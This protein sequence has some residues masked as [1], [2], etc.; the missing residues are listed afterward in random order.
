[1]RK[2]FYGWVIVGV[3]FLIGVTEAGVF[4]NILSIFM[5]P[6]AQEFGWSRASV[7]GAIAI[8]SIC[9]GL[10]SLL[11]GPILDRYGSRMVA[12]WGIVFLSIGLSALM[13]IRHLWQLYLFFGVG[14]MIAVGMLSLVISVSVSNWFIL[15]RGR[16]LGITW[17]GE[18][19]GS[20]L[21]PVM[22]QLLILAYGWRLTWGVLGVVVF[23]L[24]GIPALLFLRRRPEDMGLLPDNAGPASEKKGVDDLLEAKNPGGGSAELAEPIWTRAQATRTKT[25]WTLTLLTCLIPF[26][27]AGINFHMY[28]FLTDQGFSETTAVWVISTIAVFGAVGSITWGMLAE[29]IRIQALMAANL[30]G[31]GVVFLLFYWTVR[32]K[33]SDG[34][35]I[36]IIFLLAA[37]HGILHGGRN[38]L[39]SLIWAVFFGRSALG[40]IYSFSIPFRSVANACGP[41]FAALFFDLLGSYAL[42]FYLFAAI[43][44]ISGIVSIRMQPPKFPS[45]SLV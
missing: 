36:G 40:S 29:K 21:L 15:Q 39:V 18:R 10:I 2:P 14:R 17:I 38:T 37:M 25:F 41:I 27:Q 3:C 23:L 12:F 6:M 16:A 7:T 13:F 5:K 28:P 30:F 9:G 31:S 44:F 8:G 4:Q 20:A 11:V 19:V 22:V 34:F 1:M 32:F 24:S 43:Y 35:G 45:Y 26:L 42:P 33:F